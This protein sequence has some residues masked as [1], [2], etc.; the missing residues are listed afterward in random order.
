M[1]AAADEASDL[2]LIYFAGHGH[3]SRDGQD[4][5]LATKESS[6][7]H[8][9]HSIE[10]RELK[11]IVEASR[12]RHKVVIIDCC[13]SGLA[14]R[15][16]DAACAGGRGVRHRRG[17]RSDVGR[18]DRGV[19]LPPE[20]QRF[21]PRAGVRD[22]GGIT[23]P[24]DNKGRRG[25]EQ[26]Y[27]LTGDVL[28]ALR[29]RLKGRL[30]AGRAVPEPRI[31]SRGEGERIPLALNRAYTGKKS[32]AATAGG[33]DESPPAGVDPLVALEE[34]SATE[35][36]RVVE[37][38]IEWLEHHADGTAGTFAVQGAEELLGPLLSVELDAAQ[39]R[40]LDAHLQERKAPGGR[41]SD[42]ATSARR[43]REDPAFGYVGG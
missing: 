1:S 37:W 3:Y 34:L 4:L 8:G 22:P 35:T 36:G 31:A 10:Y 5:L 6:H 11:A 21:H 2:L 13:Y 16:G 43:L 42:E 14:V 15:M 41:A 28:R 12:A 7:R 24:L 18:R 19:D 25:E 23:G 29:T 30:E 33:A 17:L 40:R 9:Y 26:K 27:L 20:R 32:V 38:S 39:V